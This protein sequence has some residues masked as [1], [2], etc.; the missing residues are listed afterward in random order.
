MSVY[1]FIKQYSDKGRI[2]LTK[3]LIFL[4][5]TSYTVKHGYL[6]FFVYAVNIGVKTR[7]IY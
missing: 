4:M 5:Y 3:R 1:N 7:V 6:H 2:L